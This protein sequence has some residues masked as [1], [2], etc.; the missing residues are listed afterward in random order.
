MK[1]KYEVIGIVG[2]GAY[3]IVY[4]C[5]NKETDKFVAI[6][7]F[8]E[9]EDELVQKT[10]K[11]ELKMLQQ[12]KHENI[13]EF[14]ES[15]T[16]KGNLFLVFEYC[17]KNLLEVLEE[18]P[19]GLSPKLIKSFIYQMCKA[20]AYMHKNNM[21]HRD[22]KPENLLIDENL[23]LKLCD[24]GFARKVKLNKNNNNI[25]EMTD[26]VATRW[27][28]SPELLLSGGIY[29][30]DVDY[31]AVGCIMGELAD[32]NP[33]FPGENETDQI[34]C[35]INVLGNLPE[36]LVNM[37]Y[38]NPIYEGKELKHVSKVE[39]LERRY[40]GKL[41]P[42]AIDFMKGLLQ[43]DP[44]KRLNSET[45]FKHKYFACYMKDEKE[46]EKINEIIGVKENKENNNINNNK[47][48]NIK[49]NSVSSTKNEK[50]NVILVNK[51]SIDKNKSNESMIDSN[52]NNKNINSNT[53]R[54]ENVNSIPKQPT[55]TKVIN[56]TTN[57]NIINYNNINDPP[58][59][60]IEIHNNHINNN[61][62]NSINNN[63]NSNSISKTKNIKSIKNNP[64]SNNILINNSMIIKVSNNSNPKDNKIEL[65][66]TT[67]QNS[68]KLKS[69]INPNFSNNIKKNIN[70][71][72]S[73]YNFPVGNKKSLSVNKFIKLNEYPNMSLLN[74]FPNLM[75]ISL[76]QGKNN[77]VHKINNNINSVNNISS[78]FYSLKNNPNSNNNI[79]TKKLSS[80]NNNSNNSLEKKKNN[81]YNYMSL[82]NNYLG[83]YKTFFNKN[84]SNDKYN[85]DINTNY[86]K[87]EVKKYNSSPIGNYYNNVI[88]ENEEYPNANDSNINIKSFYNNKTNKKKNYFNDKKDVKLMTKYKDSKYFGK[89]NN[90]GKYGFKKNMNGYGTLYNYGY[91]K[92]N[93]NVELPQLI[94]I[95]NKNTVSK[96][97]NHFYGFPYNKKY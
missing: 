91:G 92:K 27:Y 95:Y 80:F 63:N 17:E 6:K 50:N 74:N 31:W 11:R 23:N 56:N 60:I 90:G 43:L 26:Y 72:N 30:P 97:N 1:K 58:N 85:Y 78:T 41:G 87:D 64:N 83:G 51:N 71:N 86:F 68:I 28:R 9:T 49:A 66:N 62:N 48:N 81:K 13:V 8:K 7:K 54:N 42:T 20:I 25:N 14:Q 4:K 33:M 94:Q 5:K 34:N 96:N 61:I 36:E 73:V 59:N 55:E 79:M 3:G 53:N 75:T 77:K 82:A 84:N 35:I 18:S 19:D 93:N 67:S 2:E 40:M 21:I 47:E 70:M 45:V 65:N 44:K 32:G 39:S 10:M 15:F 38:K 16:S 69:F 89:N 24:F 46:R 29:G 57:I 88:D 22:I 52:N 37:F 12:L 76:S